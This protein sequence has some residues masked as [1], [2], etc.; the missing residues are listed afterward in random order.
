[1]PRVPT[2]TPS[3][4]N[5]KGVMTWGGLPTLAHNGQ[6]PY[7]WWIF[8]DADTVDLGLW[9]KHERN[10]SMRM[11]PRKNKTRIRM[12]KKKYK[13]MLI[14]RYSLKSLKLE[15]I[16]HWTNKKRCFAP[17]KRWH[18][19]S[20]RHRAAPWL[21]QCLQKVHS[22]PVPSWKG[23]WSLKPDQPWLPLIIS[24]TKMIQTVF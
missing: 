12:N 3:Y 20:K 6:G 15:E 9:R 2:R 21:K 5:T 14:V 18:P 23:W 7:G 10:R 22:P 19:N 4:G 8:S 16:S 11:R 13:I 24:F 1:M 17:K